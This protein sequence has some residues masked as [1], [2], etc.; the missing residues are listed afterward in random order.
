MEVP[1]RPSVPIAPG[2]VPDAPPEWAFSCGR[3]FAADPKCRPPR[4]PAS[5]RKG[6]VFFPPVLFLHREGEALTG[7]PLGHPDSRPRP[8]EGSVVS[9]LSAP[10]PRPAPCRPPIGSPS[11]RPSVLLW[12]SFPLH[13]KRNLG[14]DGKRSAQQRIWRCRLGQSWPRGT[15][16]PSRPGSLITGLGPAAVL[17]EL[18]VAPTPPR[19]PRPSQDPP[20]H[21]CSTP[22]LCPGGVSGERRIPAHLLQVSC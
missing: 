12:V 22:A 6:T 14:T 8:D 16:R 19:A 10:P 7:E 9:C 17:P 3:V 21:L 13:A 4:W 11:K 1:S 5:V 20:P 18:A 2:V 15:H